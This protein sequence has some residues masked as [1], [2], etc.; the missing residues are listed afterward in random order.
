M[1]RKVGWTAGISGALLCAALGQAD[2]STEI[3]A[4]GILEKNCLGC[5]GAAQMSGLD[6]RQRDAMLKGGKRGAAIVP[7]DPEAS[8]LY[9]AVS[10]LSLIHI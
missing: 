7:G 4:I 10:G 5:H 3:A 1:L 8:L 9:R 6:L 2:P